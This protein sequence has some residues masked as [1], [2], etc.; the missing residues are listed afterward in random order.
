MNPGDRFGPNDRAST[1][2]PGLGGSA[3]DA[4][5]DWLASAAA[6]DRALPDA[7]DAP[8]GAAALGGRVAFARGGR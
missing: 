6:L 4:V 2:A 8:A 3:A 1:V 7:G 5:P